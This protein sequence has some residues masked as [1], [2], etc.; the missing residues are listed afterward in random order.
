MKKIGLALGVCLGLVVIVFGPTFWSLS[1]F[2]TA[3]II[4]PEKEQA[5]PIV[6]ILE[7]SKYLYL[8]SA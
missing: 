6:E 2:K 4:E 7:S 3:V 5:E 8:R 1:V